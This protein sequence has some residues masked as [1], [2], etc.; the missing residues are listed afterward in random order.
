MHLN[1]NVQITTYLKSTLNDEFILIREVKSQCVSKVE[2]GI[3]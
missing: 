3:S 1:P 2:L